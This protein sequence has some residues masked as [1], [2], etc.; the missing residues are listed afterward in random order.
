YY[1]GLDGP[2]F[3]STGSNAAF[4]SCPPSGVGSLSGSEVCGHPADKV[5]WAAGAG[6]KVNTWGGSYFQIQGTYA[7]GATRYV[8]FT[9]ASAYSPSQ[10]QGSSFGYGI[11]SDGVFS[12]ATGDVQLTTAFGVNAA[13]DH[14]WRPDL[15]TSLYGTYATFRDNDAANLAICL[16]QFGNGQPGSGTIAF[17]GI[18]GAST[19]GA[20]NNNFN[21]WA[22]GSR[23]QWNITPWF[24]VGFDVVYQKLES[25]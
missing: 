23:T 4:S 17:T 14:F 9:P 8:A 7:Q 13:Y 21:W 18:N 11:L 16:T 19:I 6:F 24:Y 3:T 22:V 2:L 1:A 10:F 25:A 12:N 15:R 20:C 5:G